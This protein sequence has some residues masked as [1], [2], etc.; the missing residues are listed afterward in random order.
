MVC[1]SNCLITKVNN[2]QILLSPI[3]PD[4]CF[5]G[6]VIVKE[7]EY[8]PLA[9]QT[10][11]VGENFY[12]ATSAKF[13]PYGEVDAKRTKGVFWCICN[14]EQLVLIFTPS[15][16]APQGENIYSYLKLSI[17]FNL[18]ALIAGITPDANPTTTATETDTMTGQIENGT[19]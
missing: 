13:C 10:P 7:P 14:Y 19:L 2:I 4:G 6:S 1:V 5:F 3:V 15:P 18:A 11:P 16:C 17:G 8:L 12:S 9:T